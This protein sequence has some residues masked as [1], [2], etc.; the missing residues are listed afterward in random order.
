MS[1][2]PAPLEPGAPQ[3]GTIGLSEPLI[4]GREWEYVKECLDSGWVS[5]AGPFVTRLEEWARG[6]F[7]AAGAVAVASGTAALHVAL[8]L[9]GVKGG[10]EVLVPALTFIAPAYAV[11]YVGAHPVFLDADPGTWQ[12]D[13]AGLRR[14]LAESCRREGGR[15]IDAG[16]GRPVSAVVPVH[17]LG[18]PCDMD[19]IA[20]AAHEHGL[21]VVE[22]ATE[23][24]GST[25]KGRPAG[26]LG[27]F[28]CLSFN[29]NKIV[30]A[31]G[32]GLI[33]TRSRDAAD[34]A[35]YLTTQ[36]KDDPVEYV[37]REVGFNYRLTNLQA[38]LALAQIER[39]GEFVAARRRIAAAYAEAFSGLA[40][41]SFMPEAPWATANRWLSAILVDAPAAGHDS[42]WLMRRLADAG[43]QAR[44]LWQPLHRSPAFGWD[45]GERLWV[46][47]V[48][49][50]DGLCLP[51]SASLS[52]ADQARVCGVIA[53][54]LT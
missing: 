54:S 24:L 5:S 12:L 47:D 32:G 29:G 38:A 51:S 21:A 33:L 13:P 44:P 22:D 2:D 53:E 26:L 14:F 7:P 43:I 25:Y 52:P 18:H 31:G 4:S 23:S 27:D 8:Q 6:Y 49:N 42:R 36:A 40:G 17:V 48:L 10:D 15:L 50:R 45:A 35:R 3:A 46:A 34:R 37:H 39:L 9:A 28:G 41:V 19:A 1:S 16:T 30:T 20:A 11:R